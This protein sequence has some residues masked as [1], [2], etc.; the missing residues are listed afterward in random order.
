MVSFSWLVFGGF[1]CIVVGRI[2]CLWKLCFLEFGFE[3]FLFL[4][5]R[6]FKW[7]ILWSLVGYWCREWW[8]S[9]L[10]CSV[11][12]WVGS[13]SC[14]YCSG[15]LC[16]NIVGSFGWVW[17]IWKI[18]KLDWS[19]GLGGVKFV[20]VLFFDILGEFFGSIVGGRVGLW[21]WLWCW[22][23]WRLS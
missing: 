16:K 14:L 9:K 20:L 17:G 18:F 19:R 5:K 2:V 6:W 8:S 23:L 12:G 10:I 21:W 3:V 15:L 1:E 7:W 4:V 13:C 22:L 11:K